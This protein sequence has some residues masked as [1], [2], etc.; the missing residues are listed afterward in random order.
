[1]KKIKLGILDLG[2]RNNMNSQNTI[3]DILEYAV[4]AEE[5]NFS[6]FWL[7]EHH[8]PETSIAYTNPEN[9]I[10]LI[11]GK[12]ERIRVGSAGSIITY[13]A[14]YSLVSNYKF[15]NNIY[16]DRIDFG[17][18]K[19]HNV[20]QLKHDYL[21]IEN[22]KHFKLFEEN[23]KKIYELFE[24]EL[25]NYDTKDIV[26]PPFSGKI[27]ERWYLTSSYN[28]FNTAI[29][30]KLNYCRSLFHGQNLYGNYYDTQE[31]RNF[32]E[33]FYSKHLYY[34]KVTLALG[35]QLIEKEEKITQFTYLGMNI[36]RLNCHQL[37]QLILDYQKDYEINEFI[38]YDIEE[39]NSLKM[40]NLEKMSNAF[41]LEN[42]SS[43]SSLMK[44]VN[45]TFQR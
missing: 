28:H 37:H 8:A 14:P 23:L 35:I 20:E 15:L 11:A 36:L 7:T 21:N 33:T 2:K 17:M 43:N 6:R 26:I 31:L 27:P 3:L 32:M 42:R 4:K 19:G 16:N 39:S 5:L 12:T 44:G 41:C 1:M 40:I 38:I 25:E 9:M 30:Y 22:K 13:Y 45:S 29:D 10:S 34:P 18:S 24:F